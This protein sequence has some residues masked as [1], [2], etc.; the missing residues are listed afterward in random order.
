[1]AN[2]IMI[3]LTMEEDIV[4]KLDRLAQANKR[5]RSNMVE[6]LVNGNLYQN[7]IKLEQDLDEKQSN[8]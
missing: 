1:M 4:R 2:K 8:S 3:S 6:T 5:S 7:K